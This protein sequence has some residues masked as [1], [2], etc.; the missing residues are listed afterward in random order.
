MHDATS[1]F[2]FRQDLRLSDNPGLVEACRL[3]KVL[4]IY[5]QDTTCPKEFEIGG[6]SKLWL[7]YSLK[8]LQHSLKTNL[9]LYRGDPKQI[10]A[11]LVRN[12]NITKVFWGNCYDPWGI[13]QEEAIEKILT[14]LNVT[15]KSYNSSYLY[16]PRD[17]LKDDGTYYKVFSAYKRKVSIFTPR[18]PL[19]EPKKIISIKDNSNDITIKDFRLLPKQNWYKKIIAQWE[20]GEDAA[21]K[22]L[23]EFT[24]D[25]LAGYKE[26][27]NYPSRNQTSRLSPRLHFGEISPYQIWEAVIDSSKVSEVDKGCFLNEITW[28]E[29]SCYL[30]YYFPNLYKDNFQSAFN[31]FPWKHNNSFLKAWQTGNTGY[32]II[33]AGM[34]ELW[35]TGY[36]HNRVRMIVASFLT[37]NLMIHWHYGR[38]WFW[39]CLLD[40]DLQNNSGNWQWVAGCG[41]DAA[42]YFRVFNPVLQGEKFDRDGHYTKRFVPELK[43]LPNKYLF[44]PWQASVEVLNDAK[45]VLG[46]NY[47]HP[48]VDLKSSRN[49]SLLAYRFTK[50]RK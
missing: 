12:H 40:A 6:A 5:I 50:S 21:K 48:I 10:I 22:K 41:A 16:D 26:S 28:R 29:F 37:K 7:Y 47:P 23:L 8:S 42:P 17:I 25:N 14:A 44:K 38:D 18:T 13:Q 24:H 39:D 46:K 45:V 4:P 34:R 19:P 33:D 1:I 20:V 11:D 31:R 35:Q 30:N 27:R 3:G 15:Y 9:N 2:W 49:S 43:N 32:P 36:M